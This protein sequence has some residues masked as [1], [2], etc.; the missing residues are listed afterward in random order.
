MSFD[1]V[2]VVD[3]SGGNDRGPTPKKDAIWTAT[4]RTGVSDTPQYHRNRQTAERWLTDAIAAEI[5]AGR[6]ALV[7][8]DL[9]FAYPAGFAAKLTG[10]S[11][12]FTLWDWFAARVTDT[13]NANNRF[14]LA[15]EINAGFPG[16]GPFWGNALSR[17]IPHLPRKGSTRDGH[18]LSEKRAADAAAK[19][20]FSPWQL[21]GA[22]AVGSQV[23]MGLPMLSRL[24][25]HFG[26]ALCVWPFQ[27]ADA[28][29]TLAEVYLTLLPD[30]LRTAAHPIRD[31]AQVQLFA[32]LLSALPAGQMQ[33]ML[34][35]PPS[36][37]GWVLGLGHEQ[38]LRSAA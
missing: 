28:P 10:T 15:G 34:N 26:A 22:G 17:D 4:A 32:E 5:A 12:P 31:A 8:F 7:C 13:P 11:D 29:V 19:G 38:T 16:T 27:S 20:A 9:C 18:G 25:A 23:I 33:N 35:V 24:R 3:W 1:T 37:E 36:S 21:S 30:L 14:D 2:I 6:K